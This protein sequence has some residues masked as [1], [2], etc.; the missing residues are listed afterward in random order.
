S[1]DLVLLR[2]AS[3]RGRIR[4]GR[5]RERK[6]KLGREVLSEELGLQ[7]LLKGREGRPALVVLGSLF[8]QRKTTNENSLDSRTC[9]DGSAKRHSSDDHSILGVHKCNSIAI[10]VELE[11]QQRDTT[12]KVR[13]RHGS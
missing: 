8:H 4:R 7:K 11:I 9:T 12:L 5:G 3:I 13:H 1:S 2:G 6:C 10:N